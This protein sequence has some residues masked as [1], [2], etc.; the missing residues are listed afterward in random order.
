MHVCT[1]TA[2]HAVSTQKLE[3]LLLLM[4]KEV[5]YKYFVAHPLHTVIG[6]PTRSSG[7]CTWSDLQ[8]AV[9]SNQS[10]PP[11]DEALDGAA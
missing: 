5:P 9:F 8:V 7:Y 4:I 6:Q 2:I 1:V 10:H 3:M 11:L